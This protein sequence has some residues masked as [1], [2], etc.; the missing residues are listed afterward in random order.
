MWWVTSHRVAV[1]N[2]ISEEPDTRVDVAKS[3]VSPDRGESCEESTLILPV[4][5]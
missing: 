3:E 5:R 2:T 1:R 4:Q